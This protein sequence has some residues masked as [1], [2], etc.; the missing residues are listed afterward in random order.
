MNQK[1]TTLGGAFAL[2][3]VVFGAFGAHS[4][5]TRLSA[6]LLDVFKTGAYYQMVH[7]LALILIG[8]RAGQRPKSRLLPLCCGLLI[9]GIVVFS[10]SLYVLALSGERRW[11]IVT[12]LGGLCFMAG[13]A[14]FVAAEL[15]A[16]R[17]PE[18]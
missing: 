10:G 7:S 9:T 13:W 8:Q 6:H 2:L 5:E 18:K 11:G 14:T 15:S 17:T 3:A 1:W 16:D 4:L 12:P